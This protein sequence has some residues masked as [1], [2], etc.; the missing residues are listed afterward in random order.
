MHCHPE[1]I[2]LVKFPYTICNMTI[3]GELRRLNII[4]VL[5]V[6]NNL[7]L[8]NIVGN[9]VMFCFVFHSNIIHIYNLLVFRPSEI[10]MKCSQG[11]VLKQLLDL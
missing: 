2:I 4:K 1:V 9:F 6:K 8:A 11:L 5:F 10:S 3:G 7:T